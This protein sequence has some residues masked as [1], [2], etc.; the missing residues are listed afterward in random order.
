MKTDDRCREWRDSLGAYA[1][2][3]LDAEERAG[4]EAHLEGC[5]ECRAEAESLGGVARLLPLADPARFDARRRSPPPS[6][7]SG[8]RRRSAPSASASRRRRRR[9]RFGFALGGAAGRRGGGAAGDRR[10]ARRRRAA[11]PEQ[12]VEFASLP[13]GVE[14]DATLEPH[15]FGT[16]IHMYVN[17]VRSGTL[18][19]VFLRGADGARLLGRQ[20]PL[21]LGRRL[22]RGAELGARPLPHRGDRRP[23]RQPHL[24]RPGRRGRRRR[25]RQLNRGGRDVTTGPPTHSRC[26]RSPRRWRSPAAAAATASSSGGGAYGGEQRDEPTARSDDRAAAARRRRA[27]AAVARPSPAP[28]EVGPVLVDSKGFTALRLPQGQG[29][30][31]PPATAPAPRPGRRC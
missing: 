22:R 29:H 7:A 26:W 31:R 9:R 13:A 4:L 19:R 18:C 15:A 21:P 23:R 25:Q 28:P 27:A 14:I 6:S 17:G 16:E 2:G 1:L 8:S 30:R 11:T 20:L 24:R 10:P 12:H 5:P 3:H